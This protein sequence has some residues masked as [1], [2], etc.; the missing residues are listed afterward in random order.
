M[1][2]ETLALILGDQLGTDLS[3]FEGLDRDRD[4]IWMAEAPEEIERIPTHKRRIAVFLSAMRHFRE[5]LRE[6]G[7]TVH[8]HE[9]SADPGS[10]GG[11]PL[12]FEV[13]LSEALTTL[14]PTRLAV[15]RPGC[16]RVLGS[17]ERTAAAAG[18]ELEVLADRRFACSLAEFRDWAA[19]RKR[20]VMGDFYRHMRK[21]HDVLLD[22]AGGPEGGRWSYDDENRESFGSG[23]P[24][25]MTPPPRF[26]PDTVTDGV[27]ELVE[28]RWPHHPGRL[29]GFDL[30]VTRADARFALS[31]FVEHRLDH[32]GTYQDALWPGEP[33]LSHSRLSVTLNLGLM[34]PMECVRE[35]ERA[36][37]ERGLRLA[38]VE[39]FIRQILGWREFVRGVY[40]SEMPEYGRS[41]HL[42]A[43]REIPPFLWDG[44]TEMACVA[45]AMES[46]LEHAYAHHIQ[47]LM[48]LG[49][50][51][52][53]YGVDPRR[54]ND[55]HVAMYADAVDWVSVPNT[56]GMSQY[57]D[58]GIVGTKPYCASG[59]YIDRMSPYCGDCSYDPTRALGDDAC[60]FTVLY[61]DFLARHE[62]DLRG[63]RRMGFQ[64]ANLDRKRGDG[65]DAIRA[66]AS[67]L[68]ERV[69]AGERI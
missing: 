3:V 33:F 19:G 41:N 62:D 34:A 4:G 9:L 15:T 65:L 18:V 8:Y 61:W 45:D 25:P 13:L 36:Y 20:L 54:F 16:W 46:V 5:R 51:C 24:P 59:R 60:P 27:L 23:G 67:R 53:L 58:G 26:D 40:W 6:D 63:N 52:L 37:R 14:R 1:T 39:G 43:E 42:G 32:F 28:A 66:Q 30:P 47:R 11:D 17:L 7:W 31:H 68:V 56:L 64:Y 35:A 10:P 55:W 50:F 48:V 44:R 2:L 57:A 21:R 29:D 69:E 49:L 38:S 22:P 12:G